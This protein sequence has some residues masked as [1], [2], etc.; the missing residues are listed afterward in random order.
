MTENST[1]RLQTILAAIDDHIRTL[2][3]FGL[4]RTAKLLAVAKLDLQMQLNGI[5]D[6]E[7]KE[8]CK[9]LDSA[10]YRAPRAQVVDLASRMS[11]KA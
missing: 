2:R 11:H 3:G 4:D 7:L 8:L 6:E 5:S 1:E 10:G 9:T